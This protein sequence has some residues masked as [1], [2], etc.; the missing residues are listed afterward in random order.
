MN[1]PQWNVTI[2]ED[3]ETGELVLPLPADMLVLQGWKEGDTLEWQDNKDGT[4][5]LIKVEK[6]V[7]DGNE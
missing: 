4:W 6:D 3:P 7:E 2:E 5:S 1:T